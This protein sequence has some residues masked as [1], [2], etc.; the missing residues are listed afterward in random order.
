MEIDVQE[1]CLHVHLLSGV[2]KK[3]MDYFREYTSRKLLQQ[4]LSNSV[5]ET[6][7]MEGIII[8][9]FDRNQ[10]NSL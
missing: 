6:V 8:H 1:G 9:K 4:F 5:H 10:L 2:K 7:Y 3:N